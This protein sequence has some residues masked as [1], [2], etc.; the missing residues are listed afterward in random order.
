MYRIE[1]VTIRES[2]INSE[3]MTIPVLVL[4][5]EDE[6]EVHMNEE[7]MEKRLFQI[8]AY[9]TR[10]ILELLTPTGWRE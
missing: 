6:S 3:E 9:T 1:M 7:K 8:M 2:L 4:F 5:L 10:F